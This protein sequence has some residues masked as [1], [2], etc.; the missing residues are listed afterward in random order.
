ME[1]KNSMEK[2]GGGSYAERDGEKGA[3]IDLGS[4]AI[5]GILL[6]LVLPE[7]LTRLGF[8]HIAF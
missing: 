6:P 4:E 1:V 7:R 8:N 3:R 5:V 2:R